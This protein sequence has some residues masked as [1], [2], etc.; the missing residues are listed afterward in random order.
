M[1]LR[2]VEEKEGIETVRD[3]MAVLAEYS[4]DLPISDSLGE[5]IIIRRLVDDETGDEALEIG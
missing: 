2:Y 4:S 3:M 1:A 5:G